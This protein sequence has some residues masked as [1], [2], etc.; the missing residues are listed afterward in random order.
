M[1]TSKVKDPRSWKKWK[2][3]GA[4]GSFHNKV[5][6]QVNPYRAY[7]RLERMLPGIVAH[8]RNTP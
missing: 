1:N 4:I 5:S 3:S 8:E 6:T 2:D 7:R